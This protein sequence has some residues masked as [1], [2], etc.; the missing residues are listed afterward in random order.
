LQ[1]IHGLKGSRDKFVLRLIDPRRLRGEIALTVKLYPNILA[2]KIL[3][4]HY[5]DL[6]K[7]SV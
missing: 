1:S 5:R 7:V 3:N 2:K 6:I 4:C